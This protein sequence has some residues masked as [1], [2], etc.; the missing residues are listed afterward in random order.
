LIGVVAARGGQGHYN[1]Q[2]GDTAVAG[3]YD[4]KVEVTYEAGGPETFS[5]RQLLPGDQ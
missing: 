1:W 3:T 4:A 5:Q 2:A